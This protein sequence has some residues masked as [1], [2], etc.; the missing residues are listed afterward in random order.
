MFLRA[1][2]YLPSYAS[3]LRLS[4]ESIID[5]P[6]WFS[7]PNRFYSVARSSFSMFTLVQGDLKLFVQIILAS[8][9]FSEKKNKKDFLQRPTT[10]VQK[11]FHHAAVM[12]QSCSPPNYAALSILNCSIKRVSCKK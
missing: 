3:F 2:H 8:L 7:S 4:P 11:A 6:I 1:N 12:V 10:S 5:D 9:F